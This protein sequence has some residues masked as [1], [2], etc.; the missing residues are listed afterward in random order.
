MTT[1]RENEIRFAI[2]ELAA[3]YANFCHLCEDT[4]A[5]P[6]TRT[7]HGIYH[8]L[9]HGDLN[10]CLSDTLRERVTELEQELKEGK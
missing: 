10:S 1:E 5:F 9:S 2:E 7:K 8:E 6:I 3:Q 4:A